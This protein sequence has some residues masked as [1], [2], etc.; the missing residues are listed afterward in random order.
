MTGEPIPGADGLKKPYAKPLI[1][2]NLSTETLH[3]NNEVVNY[4]CKKLNITRFDYE[5]SLVQKKELEEK[6][7]LKLTGSCVDPY[8]QLAGIW[9]AHQLEKLH[10]IYPF[11]SFYLVLPE[12]IRDQLTSQG[13]FSE[14]IQ[15]IAAEI[16]A[17][18]TG[19]NH[20]QIMDLTKQI[21]LGMMAQ[22]Q[23]GLTL[24]CETNTATADPRWQTIATLYRWFSNIETIS[25]EQTAPVPDL[26]VMP[27]TQSTEV[28]HFSFIVNKN[29]DLNANLIR[30]NNFVDMHLLNLKTLT[31]GITSYEITNP[32]LKAALDDIRSFFP[33]DELHQSDMSIL[34]KITSVWLK[35]ARG[36]QEKSGNFNFEMFYLSGHL[37]QQVLNQINADYPDITPKQRAAL[38]EAFQQFNSEL[39]FQLYK[40]QIQNM[41]QGLI[42][43]DPNRHDL[44]IT[45]Y[46]LHA[47]HLLGTATDHEF[48]NIFLPQLKRMLVETKKM[49]PQG[50]PIKLQVETQGLTASQ[51]QKLLD[52]HDFDDYWGEHLGVTVDLV[53][54]QNEF[55]LYH[56]L[57]ATKPLSAV[58]FGKRTDLI[59]WLDK[60]NTSGQE[61]VS[62]V[63]I[64]KSPPGTGP[65]KDQHYALSDDS[66][67]TARCPMLK[68]FV[69]AVS[70]YNSSQPDKSKQII[71]EAEF[72]LRD[73]DIQILLD[74][75]RQPT[76]TS[77][78]PPTS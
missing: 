65:D 25:P 69:Q 67:P 5:R 14:N 42:S 22:G 63:H 28:A 20:P 78:S 37:D 75:L 47:S 41:S 61:I 1:K 29:L 33:D 77:P 15:K 11:D 66:D 8:E 62:D 3:T 34:H 30:L 39:A 73:A 13:F 44:E 35:V 46:T 26:A 40:E 72:T 24:H 74:Q 51:W 76:S 60:I 27:P 7:H 6:Y 19:H 57:K 4:V 53:H 54:V 52:N 23:G 58:L 64:T 38:V 71:M 12:N 18:L 31:S 59:F 45:R 2:E 49:S 70:R 9:P 16:E 68:E 10:K 32:K 56:E 17:D 36:L 50:K 43:P 21:I 48:I 55:D